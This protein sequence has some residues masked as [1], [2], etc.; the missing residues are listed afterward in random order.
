MKCCHKIALISAL[1]ATLGGCGGGGGFYTAPADPAPN[2][3][4]GGIWKGTSSSGVSLIG[5]VTEAGKAYFVDINGGAQ[6]FGTM[7]TSGSALSG[8]FTGYTPFGYTFS[9]GSTSETGTL[10]GTVD[11]RNSMSF[12]LTTR[13]SGGAAGSDNVSLQFN[14]IYNQSSSLATIAGSYTESNGNALSIGSDGTITLT[15]TV[16]GSGCSVSGKVAIIDSKYNAYGVSFTFSGC[17]GNYS[18]LN[19][20]QFTGL[21]TLDTTTS[22]VKL[23]VGADAQAGLNTG[24]DG[25]AETLIF[26]R[27]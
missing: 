22:P 20:L 13:T 2:A 8:T 10:T 6:Y 21:A 25:V 18:V 16:D 3:S 23:Y 11:A 26:T 1:S 27:S 19:A 12:S 5:L 7:S 15:D 24:L 17:T 4:P 14:S 9:D